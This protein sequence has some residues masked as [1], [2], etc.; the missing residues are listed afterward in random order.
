MSDDLDKTLAAH[1]EHQRPSGEAADR[2]LQ[3]VEATLERPP[4]RWAPRVLAVSLAATAAIAAAASWVEFTAAPREVALGD[5]GLIA[6][7]TGV[8]A[9]ANGRGHAVVQDDH[10][11][12][13]WEEGTLELAVD[14]AAHLAVQVHTRDAEITVTGTVFTVTQDAFG[15]HTQVER[16]SVSV[17]CDALGT[18]ETIQAPGATLCLENA[19]AGIGRLLWLEGQE[20]SAEH[21][22]SIIDRALQFPASLALVRRTLHARRVDVLV[23]LGR[24]AQAVRATQA[25]ESEA[26]KERLAQ[27]AA[28]ALETDGCERAQPW[29]QALMREGSA[30][31][32]LLKVQC[33]AADD[34]Q[35]A[36]D[37]LAP[38]DPAALPPEQATA[39]EAW[40][41]ALGD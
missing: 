30:L 13:R 12:V 15:A 34:P 4:R 32:V 37:L 36:R 18:P 28:D 7:G 26:R 33:L 2:L 24:T 1:A 8:Q 5:D 41:Q 22:L 9:H 27:G 40:R 29:L 35:A 21:R 11:L 17:V 23:E 19:G 14:P 16:G 10:V 3:R 20:A 38:L 25:L 6:L 39:V 31:G